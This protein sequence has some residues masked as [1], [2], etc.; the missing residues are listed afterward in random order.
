MKVKVIDFLDEKDCINELE[1]L[2]QITSKQNEN[3]IIEC[4]FFTYLIRP[5]EGII[6]R[7]K[8]WKQIYEE[9]KTS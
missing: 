4:S 6:Q 5:K 1:T 9:T 8:K 2:F 7:M 3:L